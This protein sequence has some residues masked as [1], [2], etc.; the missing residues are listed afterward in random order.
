MEEKLLLFSIPKRP[1]L[2]LNSLWLN[3][4]PYAFYFFA[5]SSIYTCGG[6]FWLSQFFCYGVICQ[7]YSNHT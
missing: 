5:M 2:W 1:F 6:V 3:A 4:Q 7:I